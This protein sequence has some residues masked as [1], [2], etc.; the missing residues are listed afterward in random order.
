MDDSYSERED[1][2]GYDGEPNGSLLRAA[3]ALLRLAAGAG[4]RTAGWTVES[5]VKGIRRLSR[6]AMSG[7]SVAQLLDDA[8][9]EVRDQVRRLLGVTEIEEQLKTV[10]PDGSRNGDRETTPLREHGAEL[11]ARSA[12]VDF[13]E[14]M[15]PAYSRIL[16]Q[17]TP[18][19]ARILRVLA[20]QG[21]QAAIDIRTWRPFGMGDE[22]VAP[23]LTMLGAEAG[24][25]HLDRVPAYLN[26]LYRLGL[27]WFSREPID[28]LS[29]YQVLEAQPDVGS[30]MKRAGRARIIR[31]SIGLTPFGEDF[32]ETCLPLDTAEF[33]VLD[34][35]DAAPPAAARPEA[36]PQSGPGASASGPKA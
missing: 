9:A 24:C 5:S 29:R 31:R 11:L 34:L 13:D 4:V 15:H 10:A 28:D 2:Q 3:P 20:T 12:D 6:A 36:P 30:A 16:S 7:E 18:D 32:C 26:N 21:S 14:E 17:L 25:R 27:I 19:E 33:E 8:R 35:A 1:P 23:G 22:L